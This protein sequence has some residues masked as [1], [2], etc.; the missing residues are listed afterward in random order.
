MFLKYFGA[1]PAGRV[2]TQQALAGQELINYMATQMIVAMRCVEA[3][4]VELVRDLLAGVAG[5][6]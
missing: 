4:V 5:T 2:R 3:L 1:N 6:A